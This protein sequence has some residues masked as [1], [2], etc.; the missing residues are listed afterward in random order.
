[1]LSIKIREITYCLSCK[2]DTENIDPRIVTTKNNKRVM[3]SKCSICNNK[4]STFI[5]QGSGL[6]NTPQNRM[7]NALWNAFR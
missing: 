3:S 4:K 6:L 2:K 1:M 7:K 5:S